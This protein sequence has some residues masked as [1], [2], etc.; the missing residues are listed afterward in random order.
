MESIVKL[1]ITK[2]YTSHS[3]RRL[4]VKKI[5]EKLL[6]A[7]FIKDLQKSWLWSL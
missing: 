7:D 2:E 3:T 1:T 5:I 4:D 6:T